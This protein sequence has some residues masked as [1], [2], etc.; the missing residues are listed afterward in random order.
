[1]PHPCRPFALRVA[2]VETARM[3]AGQDIAN[4]TTGWWRPD[5]KRRPGTDQHWA[6][7]SKG[8]APPQPVFEPG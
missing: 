6:F 3:A 8:G 4:T 1:M 7:V 2:R 5:Q